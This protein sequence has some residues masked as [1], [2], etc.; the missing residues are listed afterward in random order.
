MIA[1]AFLWR[2]ICLAISVHYG[3]KFH[4]PISNYESFIITKAVCIYSPL[5]TRLFF[6]PHDKASTL[7]YV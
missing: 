3:K 2:I 1:D 5:C 7:T 6:G 4:G